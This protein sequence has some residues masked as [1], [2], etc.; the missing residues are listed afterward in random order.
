[1]KLYLKNVFGDKIDICD[2]ED[3]DA[4]TKKIEEIEIMWDE[5]NGS[6]PAPEFLENWEGCDVVLHDGEH[7][8]FYV[9]LDVG[10]VYLLR[11]E[12]ECQC[13]CGCE[14][15]RIV[16]ETLREN[17]A[18]DI[19]AFCSPA[20]IKEVDEMELARWEAEDPGPCE[21]CDRKR[22]LDEGMCSRYHKN[23]IRLAKGPEK[24]SE[25]Q[26]SIKNCEAN[27]VDWRS[28]TLRLRQAASTT[29]TIEQL[30]SAY[31]RFST[32]RS[33]G[34][35][36]RFT[37]K[38]HEWELF[39]ASIREMT[40]PP[41]KVDTDCDLMT[42]QKFMEVVKSGMI[43]DDDGSAEWGTR[44]GASGLSVDCSFEED[45]NKYRPLWA[46]HVAWFNK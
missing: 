31:R 40:E 17:G 45:L 38:D 3:F 22:G 36:S 28:E 46:T 4:A 12:G 11:K 5:W 30:R 9:D 25:W 1:M 7:E 16:Y 8:W 41:T 27:K 34:A 21:I 13:D 29:W 42:I 24:W 14:D 10:R 18:P 39:G 20:D 43:T 44:D 19:C 32:L 23:L 2:V 6:D 15:D 35:R 37:K 26:D 33:G